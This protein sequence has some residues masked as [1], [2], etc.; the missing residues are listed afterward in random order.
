MGRGRFCTGYQ[1][2]LHMSVEYDFYYQNLFL[3]ENGADKT[4]K[5]GDYALQKYH[6]S[7]NRMTNSLSMMR[8]GT[9]NADSP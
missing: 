3:L 8:D 1:T 9:C 5:N 4:L 2:A 7:R 6:T